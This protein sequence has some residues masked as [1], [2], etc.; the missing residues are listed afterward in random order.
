MTHPYL[1]EEGDREPVPVVFRCICSWCLAVLREGDPGAEVSHGI[2][3]SCAR[4]EVAAF[5]ASRYPCECGR[6]NECVERAASAVLAGTEYE[7]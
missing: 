6:C 4:R 1:P 5:K 7:E 2:C 3:R